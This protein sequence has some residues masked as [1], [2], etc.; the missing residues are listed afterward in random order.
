MEKHA[1][2]LV[3]VSTLVR[4]KCVEMMALTG[5]AVNVLRVRHV[6]TA[7]VNVWLRAQIWCVGMMVAAD[8]VVS[9]IR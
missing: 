6:M 9:V 2:M 7:R 3:C 1:M 5:A 4:I 8:L